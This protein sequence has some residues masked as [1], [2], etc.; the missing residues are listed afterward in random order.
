MFILFLTVSETVF[1]MPE[2]VI[3]I[4]ERMPFPDISA[5][6]KS[7]SVHKFGTEGRMRG[8]I[9]C[10]DDLLKPGQF[11]SGLFRQGGAYRPGQRGVPELFRSVDTLLGDYA[12]KRRVFPV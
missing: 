3:R 8:E 7:H 5:L 10:I 6:L 1:F 9:H 2:N 11:V 12:E 4:H